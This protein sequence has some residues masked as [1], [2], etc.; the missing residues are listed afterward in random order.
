MSSGGIFDHGLRERQKKETKRSISNTSCV[1]L[2]LDKRNVQ[3]LAMIF[4]VVVDGV[5]AILYRSL[6][7]L[8]GF[9]VIDSSVK[10]I[11]VSLGY[12]KGRNLFHTPEANNWL[13]L[14]TFN[15]FTSCIRSINNLF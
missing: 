12:R 11:K 9:I 13:H 3:V 4:W 10:Q 6:I 14:R 5:L 8:Y 2:L 7:N 15:R 1:L